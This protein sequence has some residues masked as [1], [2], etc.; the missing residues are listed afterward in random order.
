M[1]MLSTLSK[2]MW[3]I[4]VGE[5][6]GGAHRAYCCILALSAVYRGLGGDGRGLISWVWVGGSRTHAAG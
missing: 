4:G 2:N 1:C 3:G 5:G 6:S